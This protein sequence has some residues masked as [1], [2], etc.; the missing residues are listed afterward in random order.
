MERFNPAN[1]NLQWMKVE[2]YRLHCVEEWAE[3]PHKEAVL[4]AIRSALDRLEAS[5]LKTPQCMVCASRRAK[6]VVLVFPSKPK[7]SPDLAR[8]AA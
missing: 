8:L 4:A 5:S 1:E 2:H 3:S 6:S 7:G